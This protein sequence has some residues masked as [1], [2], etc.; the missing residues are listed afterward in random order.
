MYV[1]S[2]LSINEL[3]KVYNNRVQEEPNLMTSKSY[4]RHIFV[5]RFNLGNKTPIKDAYSVCIE[6]DVRMRAEKDHSKRN[7]IIIAQRLHKLRAKTFFS[8]LRDA[9]DN[10]IVLSFDMQKNQCLPN[11]LDQPAYFSRQLYFHTLCIVQG[12]SKCKLTK[13]SVLLLLDRGY[14]W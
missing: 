10:T 11:V 12:T 6:L 7:E 14:I 8:I 4:F 9:D 1:P 2:E 3:W 5:L 13:D